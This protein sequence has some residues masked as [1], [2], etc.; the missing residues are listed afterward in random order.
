[1]RVYRSSTAAAVVVACAIGL[2]AAPGAA[3][4]APAPPGDSV[5]LEDVRK[6]LDRLY[7]EAAVA[8]DA[9]NA[10]EEQVTEQSGTV[11]DLKKKIADGQKRLDG[12]KNRAGAAARAHYRTGGGLPPGAGLILSD[13]PEDFLDGAGRLKEGQRATEGL[14]A[15]LARTQVNL[16]IYA[17]DAAANWDELERTRKKKDSAQQKVKQKLADAEELWTSLATRERERLREMELERERAAQAAWLGSGVLDEVAAEG[18]GAG[19]KAVA[20]AR[21]QL[22]KPYEWGAEGPGSF[23]CSGLTQQAWAAAGTDIPR[24]SQEQWR[25]LPRVDESRMRPGDLIVYNTDAS[26]IALYIGDG[27]MIHAPRPG[28]SVT[29]AGAGSMPILG[30]VRPDM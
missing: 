10:V 26:H 17:E 13:D 20:Y 30:V 29:V 3:F 28:R 4:A 14:I 12:L 25:A 27:E 16:R 23:D 1:M 21:K 22:S 5:R 6:R 9:Y 8:T 11:S 18:S 2:L 15:A 19:G 24:T 7:H